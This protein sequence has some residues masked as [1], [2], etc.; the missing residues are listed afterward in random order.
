MEE[1]KGR[2][3][4]PALK[5]IPASVYLDCHNMEIDDHEKLIGDQSIRICAMDRKQ[6]LSTVQD[7]EAEVRYLARAV[8]F[9]KE[10][11]QNKK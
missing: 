5:D 3:W 10:R 9:L 11:L 4:H 7:L 6:L 1:K 2:A 8:E